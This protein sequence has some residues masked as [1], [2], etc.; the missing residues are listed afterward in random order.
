MHFLAKETAISIHFLSSLFFFWTSIPQ[1]LWRIGA[2]LVV[3][4]FPEF[5]FTLNQDSHEG[6]VPFNFF[7]Y[8]HE[9]DV[10]FNFF[11]YSHEGDVPFNFFFFNNEKC[12]VKEDMNGSSL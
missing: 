11:F 3:Q 5:N 4:F 10:P 2:A 6:D 9:G 7:F 8:S 1:S 12:M